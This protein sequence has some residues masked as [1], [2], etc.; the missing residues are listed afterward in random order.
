MRLEEAVSKGY[1]QRI[2]GGSSQNASRLR[3]KIENIGELPR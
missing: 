2:A 3:R 1:R